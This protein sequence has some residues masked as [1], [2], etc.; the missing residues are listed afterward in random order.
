MIRSRE[1]IRSR[2]VSLIGAF[3]I[4]RLETSDLIALKS[5]MARLIS[6]DHDFM[7]AAIALA[8]CLRACS[9]DEKTSVKVVKRTSSSKPARR[10]FRR[11]GASSR[12]SKAAVRLSEAL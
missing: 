7:A 6:P 1:H 5:N 2:I 4:E 3:G 8:F 10:Y 12:K 9:L 11:W